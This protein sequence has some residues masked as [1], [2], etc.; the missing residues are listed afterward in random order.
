MQK[1]IVIKRYIKDCK[2]SLKIQFSKS[3]NSHT[4]ERN[5]SRYLVIMMSAIYSSWKRKVNIHFWN[6]VFLHLN[7]NKVHLLRLCSFL[8]FFITFPKNK[9][10]SKIYFQG[11]RE[12]CTEIFLKT[13]SWHI[14]KNLSFSMSQGV[15][16]IRHCVKNVC[17]CIWSFPGPYF[18]TFGMNTERY[19]VQMWEM[20]TRK[21]QNSDIFYSVRLLRKIFKKSQE[22]F[23]VSKVAS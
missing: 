14:S 13:L 6:L 18:P 20:R 23:R 15:P 19:S 5:V 2:S 22:C 16:K 17:I 12:N 4:S 3:K 7:Y 8:S 10:K 1:F 11:T 9:K 21:T